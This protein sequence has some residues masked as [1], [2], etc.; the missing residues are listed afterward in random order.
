MVFCQLR[1]EDANR[2]LLSG[3]SAAWLARLVRDQEVEGSNPFAP[4]ILPN[5]TKGICRVAETRTLSKLLHL[6]YILGFERLGRVLTLFA[7]SAVIQCFL[8]DLTRGRKPLVMSPAGSVSAANHRVSTWLLL[9]ALAWER[10][11]QITKPLHG[12][13]LH[14]LICFS[15]IVTWKTA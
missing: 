14:F 15:I 2:R 9:D 10:N 3:R 5:K 1:R 8:A 4:T 11:E 7:L 6:S 12:L 13:P